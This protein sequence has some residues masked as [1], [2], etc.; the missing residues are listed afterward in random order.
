MSLTD[1][2]RHPRS[3]MPPPEPGS[4]PRPP[5]GPSTHAAWRDLH[6]RGSAPFRRGGRFAWHFA[7][8]KLQHD[9]VFRSMLERGD[10]SQR[11]R[12]LDIGCGQGL[13]PS[14]LQACSDAHAEGRWPQAWPAA[15]VSTRYTGIELMARD[16]QRAEH[17]LIGL[18]L[19]PRFVCGDMRETPVPDCDVVVILDVLHYVE[20]LEQERIL[21]RVGAA[22]APGGRLL[23]RVGDQGQRGRFALSRWVDHVVCTLRGHRR[24][25][26]WG[27]TVAE[28]Q[29]LLEAQGFAVC[30]VP[31]HRGTPFANMLLVADLP[32]D[33]V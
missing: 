10:L 30:A 8:G 23:L 24:P 25:P 14:L 1:Q 6:R 5:Q 2:L 11:Q 19:A 26:T 27:R 29:D 33:R 16:V 17:S 7:R 12:V 15:P 3:S 9:P 28:W 21:R 31:M 20:H 4:Q 22:L 18:A 13:L 32:E